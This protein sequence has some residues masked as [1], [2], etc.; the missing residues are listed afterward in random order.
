MKE[1][2]KRSGKGGKACV[3]LNGVRVAL[4]VKVASEIL[5]FHWTFSASSLLALWS[6]W[7]SRIPGV[8]HSV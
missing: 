5:S 8:P 3:T 4:F 7:D 2:G 6:V 1:E